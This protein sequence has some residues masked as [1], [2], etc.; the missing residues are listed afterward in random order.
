MTVQVALTRG[1]DRCENI[2]Q[3]VSRL[4][5]TID[6]RKV[7]QILIKPNLVATERAE[8]N[9]HPEAVQ[10]ILEII[11]QTYDGEILIAEGAALCNSLDSF[12]RFGYLDMARDFRARLVDLN[13]CET[14]PVRVYNIWRRPMRLRL[15][16]PVVDAG[17]RISIGPPKTHNTVLVSL[18]IKNMVM[19]T[20]V[21][22]AMAS[23]PE[24]HSEI[25]PGFWETINQPKKQ[26]LLSMFMPGGKRSDKLFMHQ[27]YPAINLNIAIL[28]PWV[29]PH[30][31]IIDGFQGM[32][33]N[34]PTQG[35]MVDWRVC[36][37]GTDAVAVDHLTAHLMGFNPARI[38]YLHYCQKMG[39]GEGDLQ[40]IEVLSDSEPEQVQRNFIPS[41]SAGRQYH[42]QSRRNERL[43]RPAIL[44]I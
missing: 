38:G 32:E 40:H 44:A 10:T 6:L 30:L 34:G 7:H 3:A 28:A 14:V 2:R 36:L 19:G 23:H 24:C 21:N 31:A 39:L 37:A 27:G 22:P 43:L 41:P 42:W 20:L 35:R 26:A 15:A 4:N 9:T 13:A 11:R 33:G 8:A 29:M 25:E 17:F 1:N 5:H 12:R 18:S 16:K